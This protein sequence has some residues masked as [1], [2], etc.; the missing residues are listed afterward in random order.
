MAFKIRKGLTEI[1]VVLRMDDAVKCNDDEYAE[2]IASFSPDSPGDESLLKLSEDPTRFILRLNLSWEAKRKVESGNMSIKGQNVSID[3]YYTKD[4]LRHS[5]K[6]IKNPSQ[7]PLDEQL[8]FVKDSS[9]KLISKS[10]M[11]DLEQMGELENLVTALSNSKAKSKE[12][13]ED[14]AVEK[15]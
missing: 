4:L 13:D 3:P 5:F 8:K 7:V 1:S 6:S 12:D 11:N 14:E 10:F 15:N 2:Y 9:D